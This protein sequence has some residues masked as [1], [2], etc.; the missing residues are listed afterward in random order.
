[1]IQHS[2]RPRLVCSQLIQV[3]LD[4]TGTTI[5]DIL[6]YGGCPGNLAAIRKL[7][8]GRSVDEVCDLLEGND[9]AGRGTSCADQLTKALREAQ[10]LARA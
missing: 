6:F 9:C 4:D 3:A 1:M 7:V 8:R 10:A 2:Y 5:E